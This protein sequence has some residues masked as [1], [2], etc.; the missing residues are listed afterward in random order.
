MTLEELLD[1]TFA[2]APEAMLHLNQFLE[3]IEIY[4]SEMTKGKLQN[5]KAIGNRIYAD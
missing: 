1:T 4:S 3:K 2:S 5:L